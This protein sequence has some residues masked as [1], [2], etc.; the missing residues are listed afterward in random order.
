MNMME[1]WNSITAFTQVCRKSRLKGGLECQVMLMICAGI[2][3][4]N[5]H[6]WIR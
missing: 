4:T 1:K 3:H 2:V 5:L 6:N